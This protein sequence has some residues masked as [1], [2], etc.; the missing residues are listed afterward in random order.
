MKR[1]LSLLLAFAICCILYAQTN[2][3]TIKKK[4]RTVEVY[5]QVYDV[6]TKAKLQAHITLMNADS[7]VIDT[8]TCWTWS[9]NSFYI[10][11]VPAKPQ[12]LI[13]KA[14][15][16]GY[17][18]A[19]LDYELKYLARNQQFE[20]P[21][22]LMKKKTEDIWK[23]SELD[24]VVVKGTK[25]K[26]AYKGDTIVYNASA[27][28]LPEGS[29]LDG[30]VR[31]LPGAEL[32]SNGDIYIN[33]EK[34]DYL[35]LNGK[36][37]FK[38]QN[39]VML[40][41][42]PYYTV[43]NIKVFHQSTKQSKLI[44][45]EIERKEY[46]MDVNLKREYNRGILGNVEAGAGT[47]ER[48][49]SR[50]FGLYFDDHSRISIY[51]NLNN[52]NENRT[53]GGEGDWEPSNMPEG[54]RTTK[55]AGMD[56]S[57]EDADKNF[58]ENGSISTEWSNTNN[59]SRTS[60]ETF[61]YEGN[62][63]NG[64]W[65][66]NKQKDFR[67]NI[68][69]NL[70]VNNPI[71]L[72]TDFSFDYSQGK[73]TSESQDS[74]YR[75]YITNQSRH[76]SLNEW[77]NI[78]AQGTANY[79]KKLAWGDY[80]SIQAHFF[81]KNNKPNDEF[82]QQATSYAN[83]TDDDFRDRY[84]D[85]HSNTYDWH[86]MA[87]YNISLLNKWNIRPMVRYYQQYTSNYNSYYRL[88]WLSDMKPHDLGWLPSVH[89]SLLNVLDWSNSDENQLF[90][91]K[92][93][94]ELNINKF[95]DDYYIEFVL[96]F[97][98]T[99]ERL[100]FY[101]GELDTIAHRTFN[102]IRPRINIYVWKTGFFS[103]N[104]DIDRPSLASLMP[105]DESNNPLYFRINNL[106]LKNHI[107]HR[108]NTR[109]T[110]NV[111]SLKRSF[112]AW[113]NLRIEKGNW[114]TRSLYDASDGS[115]IFMNDNVDGNWGTDFGLTYSFP[116]DKKKRFTIT[117]TADAVYDHSVDFDVLY[118]T[119]ISSVFDNLHKDNFSTV[120]NWTLHEYLQM[121]YQYEDL[122][123]ILSGNVS[124]RNSTGNKQNFQRINA[125]DFDYGASI[126]YTIPWMKLGLASD[127]RMFSRRGYYSDM[128]NDNHLV[129]NAQLTRSL[130]KGRLVA[131]LQVF[132]LLHQLSSTQ[133]SVNAQGRTETW[134]NCI[135]RYYMFTLLYK[136]TQKPKVK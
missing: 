89:D 77:K 85:T 33:G 88:D 55:Q 79:Y 95:H 124:W 117:E 13:V 107:A 123:A 52:V 61:A 46:V 135:P 118:V 15:L 35:T 6:F 116:I 34:I 51:G 81:F 2:S 30:L 119:D 32:K 63:F 23:E 126:N 104:L 110:H 98:R 72:F 68:H 105:G 26:I 43:Q 49:M 97:E 129:W 65:G 16:N 3:E 127:I 57:T 108:I 100:H 106:E 86:I 74:T 25:V 109:F 102:D 78:S 10:F 36:D 66:Q 93:Y 19:Y 99:H 60:S 94:A 47:E 31:Q 9:T 76:A 90:T 29:M 73:R 83:N 134:H 62:I 44:G 121:Q 84:A 48:Y 5:G 1:K 80:F 41:N 82:S 18:D 111:D 96:P 58:E 56:F 67:L 101:D 113:A 64:S 8:T 45:Q 50:L 12:K 22:L 132:D 130:A 27:F 42:L 37:F 59:E 21:R 17:E 103:Y 136:F 40:D 71:R 38:G 69:N 7:T 112:A 125:F 115:Y 4:E 131:K 20:L 70:V 39:K 133:Y 87:N 53:P 114:G 14:E 24:D 120:K 75:E 91:R 11:R 54:L 128:M 92:Y 122:T 28:N